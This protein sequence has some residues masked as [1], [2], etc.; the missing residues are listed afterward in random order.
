MCFTLLFPPRF[1]RLQ[2]PPEGVSVFS[3]SGKH[4]YLSYEIIYYPHRVCHPALASW[5]YPERSFAPLL[6]CAT[7]YI[8]P[9][10]GWLLDR[11]HFAHLPRAYFS[12][13]GWLSD[14]S[15][16]TKKNTHRYPIP[17]P[18]CATFL[19]P[20]RFT[21]TGDYVSLRT[22]EWFCVFGV[23]RAVYSPL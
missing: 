11:Y 19:F 23:C 10:A 2:L 15:L 13:L 12:R 14:V 20:A 6:E 5:T 9:V 17:S 4:P 16:K 3:D 8:F 7:Q 21:P 18:L 1:P 22:R